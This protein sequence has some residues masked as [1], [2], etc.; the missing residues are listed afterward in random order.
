MMAFSV[1]LQGF[2]FFNRPAGMNLLSHPRGAPHDLGI[3]P[4]IF[5]LSPLNAGI[6]IPGEGGTLGIAVIARDRRHR[7]DRKG[8]ELAQPS[9]HPINRSPDH[10]IKISVG[11]LHPIRPKNGDTWGYP[12]GMNGDEWGGMAPPRGDT[13]S[14]LSHL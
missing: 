13:R 2:T 9:D 3:S 12:Q 7:R 4:G 10:P 1:S 5:P 6:E 11:C 8:K 14:G